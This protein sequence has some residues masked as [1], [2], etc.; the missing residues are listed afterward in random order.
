MSFVL[1]GIDEAGYGP[2]LGPLCVGMT[3]FE[4][5][6]GEGGTVPCLWRVLSRAVCREA[7]RGGKPGTGG[8]IPVA[9]SKQLKLSSSVTTTHP[10]VH[11]ERGVLCM[12]R[13]LGEPASPST[14]LEL[15]ALLGAAVP[16]P[17]CYAG[18]AS[19]IPCGQD[20]GRLGIQANL[21]AGAVQDAGVRVHAMRCRVMDEREF[22]AVAGA[23]DNKAATTALA[24]GEHLRW[25]WERHAGVDGEGRARLGVVCD[26]L[27]GRAAYSDLLTAAVP[28]V[29]VTVVEESD[30]RSRYIVERRGERRMGVSFL[31]EGEQS[32]MPVALASMVAKYVR[33]LCMARFNRGW[34]AAARD[35]AGL[36]LKPTAG[37][38]QDARRWLH[39]AR[40][41]LT[42]EDRAEL[43]RRY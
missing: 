20:A 13:C 31:V 23:A 41:V 42:G 15:F 11:L 24:V 25:L 22:N 3:A 43:V 21:L 9:D 4:V 30:V 36:E 10:L 16:G 6:P 29:T 26:R 18:G 19:A 7:G 28:G 5:P 39:D 32:H 34:S 35:L 12:A 40:G 1:A 33:E 14:D 27:G 17:H 8:R 38:A 37:Y 2:T